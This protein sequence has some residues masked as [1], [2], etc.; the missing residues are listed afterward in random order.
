MD[1]IVDKTKQDSKYNYEEERIANQ[2]HI[3]AFLPELICGIC[4]NILK[5]PNECKTCE[6]PLC[7]DC[8][9]NWFQRNPNT[10]PFCRN[11]SQFDRVNRITRNLLSKI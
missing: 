9:T 3:A 11:K 5:N 10:C 7:G 4:N 8:K 1:S 2:A 6:K